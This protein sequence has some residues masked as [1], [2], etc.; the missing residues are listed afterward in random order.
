[1]DYGNT[2]VLDSTDPLRRP[3]AG[4]VGVNV[5][6][7]EAEEDKPAGRAA[8]A[9]AIACDLKHPLTAILANANAARRWLNGPDAN[10]AEAITALGRIAKD[11]ARIDAAL[12]SIHAMPDEAAG[13]AS[14][15]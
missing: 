10:P 5:P 9:G 12:D 6:T 11:V 8:A 15:A 7:Q 1:M 2:A 13:K 14:A 3:S 4:V